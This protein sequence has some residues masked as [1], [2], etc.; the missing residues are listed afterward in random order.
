MDHYLSLLALFVSNYFGGEDP[1]L[2]WLRTNKNLPPGAF[3]WT[4]DTV[5]MYTN[6]NTKH[7]IKIIGE[8]LDELSTHPEFPKDYSLEAV[9]AAM[10]IIMQSNHFV[11]GD[12]NFLQ[13]LG[14]AM[15][16]SAACMW[17]TIYYGYHEVKKLLPT[18]KP[19]LWDEKMAR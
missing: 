9:K 19:Q 3:L 14:T 13:L 1:I 8:W 18:F 4:S 12:L 16:T 2:D 15:G 11:F 5:S 7:A 17:A 6:I 10:E